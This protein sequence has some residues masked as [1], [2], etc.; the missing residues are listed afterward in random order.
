[1]MEADCT[2]EA[3]DDLESYLDSAWGKINRLTEDLQKEKDHVQW[4]K[5]CGGS[6]L[7]KACGVD[8]LCRGITKAEK[9]RTEGLEKAIHTVEDNK[10]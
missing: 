3:L 4:L 7:V 9:E 2:Q 8:V 10:Q 6:W 5:N 1:M